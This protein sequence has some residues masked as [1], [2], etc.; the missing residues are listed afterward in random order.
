MENISKILVQFRLHFDEKEGH[1]LANHEKSQ[2]SKLLVEALLA[3]SDDSLSKNL[4]NSVDVLIR[5]H[6][7]DSRDVQQGIFCL[8][9]YSGVAAGLEV[10]NFVDLSNFK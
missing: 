7:D 5:L 9:V 6:E 1:S 3:S 2:Y 10:S 8:H 4:Q